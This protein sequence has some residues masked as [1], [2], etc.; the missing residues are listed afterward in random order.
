MDSP[1]LTSAHR[2]RANLSGPRKSRW[3]SRGSHLGNLPRH[4]HR[5]GRARRGL[6]HGSRWR[7]AAL[8]SP[9]RQSHD[10][11]CFAW[12]KYHGEV[13]PCA[14]QRKF[15]LHPLGRYLRHHGSLRCF[16]F[17]RRWF[18]PG[19]DCRC[20]RSSTVRRTRSTGRV[21]K[22]RLGQRCASYERRP[23]PCADAHDRGEH[24]EAT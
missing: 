10:W 7:A 15:P 8:H 17:H 21:D 13:V 12:W 5:A 24:G 14:S 1:Q 16:I 3:Q 18:A 6:F 20:E 19:F 9:Y 22:A 23:W 4:P 2:N 11:H